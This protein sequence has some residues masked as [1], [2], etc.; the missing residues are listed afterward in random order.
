MELHHEQA[1]GK[2]DAHSH[3]GISHTGERSA[4]P[5]IK[6][7]IEMK[8]EKTITLKMSVQEDQPGIS[9]ASSVLLPYL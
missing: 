3:E 4:P 9:P 5:P 2:P 8:D 6:K 7:L 1:E